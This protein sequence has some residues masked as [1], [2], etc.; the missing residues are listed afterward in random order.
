MKFIL[1]IDTDDKRIGISGAVST[2]PPVG[3]TEC[4]PLEVALIVD[5]WGKSDWSGVEKMYKD[6]SYYWEE[7]E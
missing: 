4:T 7:E 2:F 5:A 6:S 3:L 1:V